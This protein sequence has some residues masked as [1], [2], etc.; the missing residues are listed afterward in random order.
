VTVLAPTKP[1]PLVLEDLTVQFRV[2]GQRNR[3]LTAVNH[4][5]LTLSPGESLGLVGESGCGKSTVAR[6]VAGLQEPTSGVVR[7]GAMTLTARRPRALARR[8]QMVFQDPIS[9]LNPRMTVGGVLAEVLRVHQIVDRSSVRARC[10]ELVGLV[11]LPVEVLGHRPR[12]LSGGQRQ[13]VGIARAIAPQPELLILDEAIASLDV[14]V[15]ASVLDLLRTLRRDLGLSMVFISHDLS[16]VRGL[17][18]RVAVMYLGRI[19]EIGPVDAVLRH[20]AHPYTR[21][22]I[23]AEPDLDAVR[24]PGTAGLQGEPP[25]AIDLPSGCAFRLR[26]P[27]AHPSCAD[28]VPGIDTS[29]V[30]DQACFFPVNQEPKDRPTGALGEAA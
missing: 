11:G 25:S 13:R 16:A 4:L 19:V 7:L 2:H 21:A 15:Q 30:H 14:S 29:A 3:A 6:T 27:V 1:E 20:P 22:L 23:A 28:S 26:C 18:S 24:A 8:I 10:E 17:C 12:G 9:S 5:S